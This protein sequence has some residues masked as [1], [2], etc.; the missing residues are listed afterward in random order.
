MLTKINS[1]AT[2]GL[3]CIPIDVEVDIGRGQG[4]QITIV[5]L[6][7]TAVSEAKERVGRSLQNSGF[8]LPTKKIVINLAPG[9]IRKN[10]V[11][12][13]LPIAVGML[14]S[15]SV[16]DAENIHPLSCFVGELGLD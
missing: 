2:F 13:D 4:G 5:G 3:Q 7:D 1:V 16:V 8:A 15:N 11:L 9:D 10:G 14:T 6:P 12:F